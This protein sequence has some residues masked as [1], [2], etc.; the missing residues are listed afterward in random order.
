MSF[1][2]ADQVLITDIYAAGESPVAG[3]TSA[4]LA[5]EIKHKA[6]TY[7]EKDAQLSKKIFQQ[8][9]SGDVFLTLGAGDGWKVGMEVLEQLRAKS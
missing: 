3:I 5:Q 1:P 8:L 2:Q 4:R 6:C 7:F 9:K